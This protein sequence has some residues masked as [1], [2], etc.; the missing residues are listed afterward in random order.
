MFEARLVEGKTLKNVVDAIKDLVTDANLD[1]SDEGLDVQSMD[2]S[3]VALVCV[4]LLASAFDH[5][6]CDRALSL[7]F[8]SANLTK[9]FKMMGRN[10]LVTLK[11][12][13]QGDALTLM[14]ESESSNTIADFELKLMQ[15]DGE[16]LG[17]P[18]QDYACN[19]TMASEEF[20]RIVRDLQVLGDACTI[21]CT[22]EG[23][24]FS[25][26]GQIGTGNILLRSTGG[27]GSSSKKKTVDVDM[28][29][30]EDVKPKKKESAAAGPP[31]VEI[32]MTEPVELQ[33]ALRYLTFFTKATPLSNVVILR[34]SPDIPIL[35]EYPIAEHG[36]VRYYLAPKIE[37]DQE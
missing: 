17:I 10:D 29:D 36:H 37:D 6:R 13:D 18:E 23:I 2:S 8:N 11:A 12:E 26:Q 25:V 14:F 22:K 33:F 16:N 5:Y 19:V 7:G 4:K 15:I 28:D 32:T 31:Q 1:V 20:Q 9:I 24:R 21:S 34:L 3:H 27:G 35:L 30:D